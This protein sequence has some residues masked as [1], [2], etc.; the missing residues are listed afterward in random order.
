[1][2][3]YDKAIN[4]I[5]VTAESLRYFNIWNIGNW[6]W[7]SKAEPI[8]DRGSL[9]SLDLGNGGYNTDLLLIPKHIKA[10]SSCFLAN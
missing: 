8:V 1:M 6:G 2:G 7:F 5:S 10:D 4:G 3:Y 9:V